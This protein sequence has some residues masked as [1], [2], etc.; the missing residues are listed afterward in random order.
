MDFDVDCKWTDGWMDGLMDN[1]KSGIPHMYLKS[2]ANLS[3]FFQGVHT[4]GLT[5]D[6]VMDCLWTILWTY[7]GLLDGLFMD[8]LMDGL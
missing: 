1:T 2:K 3:F 5:M 4:Y 7:C 8:M 6:Y